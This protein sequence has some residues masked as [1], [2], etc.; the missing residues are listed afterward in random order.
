M[1]APPFNGIKENESGI[2]PH[3]RRRKA[4][5]SKIARDFNP[6][7]VPVVSSP[8]RSERYNS[9]AAITIMGLAGPI[10]APRL[11]EVDDMLSVTGSYCSQPTEGQEERAEGLRFRH[12]FNPLTTLEMKR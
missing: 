5:E 4:K 9:E 6:A 3:V 1:L 8:C 2:T 7:P 10:T 11:S 12:H